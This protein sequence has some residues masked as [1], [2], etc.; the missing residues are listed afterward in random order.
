MERKGIAVAGTLLVDNFCEIS[1]YPKEGELTKINS[2]KMS[3][4]GLVPN[5][6]IGLKKIAPKM[7]VYAVGVVGNDDAGAFA[8]QFMLDAGVDVSHVVT[9]DNARTSFTHVM[10]VPGA[11]RTF[12]TYP[13]ACAVFGAE[14]ID[15]DDL[16]CKML[17]L[18]YF[19]LLD[20]VDEGEGEKIL[21]K[22]KELGIMT[23]IDLVSEN[24]DRYKCVLPCLKYVDNLIINELEAGKL[25]GM[26]PTEE[27]LPIIAKKLL[28]MGVNQRVIIHQPA[29]GLCCSKDGVTVL[30]STKLPKGYVKGKTGAGDAF[31]SG[32]L[33]AI[34]K[35]MSDVDILELAEAAAVSSL[36]EVDATG[37][38]M[39]ESL[40]LENIRRFE[41]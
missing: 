1:S 24:S 8:K 20:R 4:G 21:K 6:G 35:G 41:R 18:G 22:A 3:V 31:C 12:F 11:Q 33:I 19:L 30:K 37:G 38:I 7:P 32:A 25:A 39:E 9:L 10:S 36:T 13:G 15:W 14:H 29:M 16:N 26:E 23:S 34:E 28:D 17:H 27:N 2:L 40:I 5:N